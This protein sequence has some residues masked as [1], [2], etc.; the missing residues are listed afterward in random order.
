MTSRVYN[1]VLNF[2]ILVQFL[3]AHLKNF[4]FYKIFYFTGHRDFIKNMICGAAQ[5]DAAILVL[6]AN[7]GAMPQTREHLLLVKQVSRMCVYLFLCYFKINHYELHIILQNNSFL[8]IN[9][10]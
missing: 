9:Y 1:V 6:A 7:D 5:L 4:Q 8:H 10:Y 2:A 3:C